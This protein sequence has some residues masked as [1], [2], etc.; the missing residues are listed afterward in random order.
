[1][2]IQYM[3]KRKEKGRLFVNS[4]SY[5]ILF[6]FIKHDASIVELQ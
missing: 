3:Y 5:L 2:V 6:I 4:R 1:M